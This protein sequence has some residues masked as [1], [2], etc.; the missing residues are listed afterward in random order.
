MKR[1]LFRPKQCLWATEL[2]QCGWKRIAFLLL[3]A[4]TE[5][6]IDPRVFR[7]AQSRK[8]ISSIPKG[9]PC[10]LYTFSSSNRQSASLNTFFQSSTVLCF[11]LN[12]TNICKSI[13]L[14]NRCTGRGSDLHCLL[15]GGGKIP[16]HMIIREPD[17]K[18]GTN[19][20]RILL[21]YLSGQSC[22]MALKK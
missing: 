17:R 18:L 7:P 9:D 21:A 14:R 6:I 8:T 20:P 12:K 22:S 10:N 4:P 13:T 2:T 19:A 1:S 3:N 16:S 15:P 5:R 11:A